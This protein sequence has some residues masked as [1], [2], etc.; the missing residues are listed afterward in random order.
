MNRSQLLYAT[1]WGVL[2]SGLV[3][4]TNVILPSPTES[5]DEYE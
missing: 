4:L 5:D 1:A 2:L 3:V